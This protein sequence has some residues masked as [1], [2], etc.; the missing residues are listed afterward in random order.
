MRK[1]SDDWYIYYPG[2]SI[3][4]ADW[5]EY[6]ARTARMLIAFS[7]GK[8]PG[9]VWRIKLGLR[10]D[11][12]KKRQS[13]DYTVFYNVGGIVYRDCAVRRSDFVFHWLFV[14]FWGGVFVICVLVFTVFFILRCDI[15]VVYQLQYRNK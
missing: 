13:A 15:S 9:V 1:I 4:E 2:Y 6:V 12:S 10:T 8:T 3:E 5:P 11:I 14:C 7:G